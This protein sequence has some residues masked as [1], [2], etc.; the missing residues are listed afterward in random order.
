M[1]RRRRQPERTPDARAQ[2]RQRLVRLIEHYADAITGA[3]HG[4]P[5]LVQLDRLD[6]GEPLVVHAWQLPRRCWP[7]GATISDRLTVAAD[8]TVTIG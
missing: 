5:W 8:G 2:L 4:C 3:G 1:A 6:A 7:A